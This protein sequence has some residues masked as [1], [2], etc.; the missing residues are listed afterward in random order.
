M[1]LTHLQSCE[2]GGDVQTA[3]RDA[4]FQNAKKLLMRGN[5]ELRSFINGLHATSAAQ[6]IVDALQK[7][8]LAF[9]NQLDVE[10]V[11]DP[12]LTQPDPRV[13]TAIYR[14]VQESL[15]NVVRHS[16]SRKARVEIRREDGQFF[17]AIKDWGTGF[18][19]KRI[20]PG[21][22]GLGGIRERA[23]SLGGEARVMSAPGEGTRVVVRIP[24]A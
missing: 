1:A 22:L 7:V 20:P 12:K 24:L 13:S 16:Q 2:Q 9:E 14:I 17:V 23:R 5:D 10:L 6:S 18:D 8:I 4:A 15:A 11:H 3:I 21:R 19:V